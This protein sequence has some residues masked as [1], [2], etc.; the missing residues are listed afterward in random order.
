MDF[1]DAGNSKGYHILDLDSMEYEFFENK[2]SPRYEKV[3]LSELVEEGDITPIVQNKI[4]NNIVKLKVDKNIS[5]DDMDILL[6]VFNKFA[7]EQL[8]VDYDINF[9]RILQDREDI[10]DMSGVDVEQAIEDFIGTMDLDNAKSIIEYTLGL[11][12]RCKR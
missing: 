7:P 12:E 1:G 10:E 6:N 5:Q 11:Y 3:F 4:N 9:N 8:S 2:V